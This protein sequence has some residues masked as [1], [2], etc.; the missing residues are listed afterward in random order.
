MNYTGFTEHEIF[1]IDMLRKKRNEIQYYG[2][3]VDSYYVKRNKALFN[4]MINKFEDMIA[5][6]LV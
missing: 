6:K 4:A 2:L 5:K 1:L 3:S